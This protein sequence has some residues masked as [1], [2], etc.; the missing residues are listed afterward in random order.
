MKPRLPSLPCAE[1]FS[2]GLVGFLSLAVCV[3]V[4]SVRMILRVREEEAADAKFLETDPTFL[5]ELE[6]IKNGS[7]RGLRPESLADCQ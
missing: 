1:I 6:D 7:T 5:K 2:I 3:S 4:D